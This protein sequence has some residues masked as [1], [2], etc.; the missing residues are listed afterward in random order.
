MIEKNKKKIN[1]KIFKNCEFF[2]VIEPPRSGPSET[3]SPL[4]ESP[5]RVPAAG[6]FF[7]TLLIKINDFFM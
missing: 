4:K 5:G 2:R 6:E 7:Y 3:C 1:I